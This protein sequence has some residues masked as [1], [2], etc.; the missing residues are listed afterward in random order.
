MPAGSF[1]N[2]SEPKVSA[3]QR[4]RKEKERRDR[5]R[6]TKCSIDTTLPHSYNIKKGK[7]IRRVDR[8]KRLMEKME[9][10]YHETE[11][12]ILEKRMKA[13][14][15]SQ[16][17]HRLE[18]KYRHFKTIN[19]PARLK[20][21]KWLNLDNHHYRR[22]LKKTPAT[23]QRK[24]WRE[25]RKK[26]NGAILCNP[27]TVRRQ[28]RQEEIDIDNVININN[29]VNAEPTFNLTE[30]NENYLEK[31]QLR[32]VNPYTYKRMKVLRD[33]DF[34][35]QVTAERMEK[36][37]HPTYTPKQWNMERKNMKHSAETNPYTQQRLKEAEVLSVDNYHF[38][39]RLKDQGPFYVKDDWLAERKEM[40]KKIIY[41]CK[42]NVEHKGWNVAP[43]IKRKGHESESPVRPSTSPNRTKDNTIMPVRPSSNKNS[44]REGGNRH[45]RMRTI[46]NSPILLKKESERLLKTLRQQQQDEED[47]IDAIVKEEIDGDAYE[48]DDFEEE[49][50]PKSINS[51]FSPP[52]VIITQGKSN[53]IRSPMTT[54]PTTINTFNDY[55]AYK[56]LSKVKK[57]HEVKG[58][59]LHMMHIG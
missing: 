17:D 39:R 21:Q 19:G 1:G 9:R 44:K 14:N 24:N 58:N 10:E 54:S 18:A 57:I 28:K 42:L 29:I 6:K 37:V 49:I 46:N 33:I 22:R 43:L 52:R 47:L 31:K 8:K 59:S 7:I 15:K 26:T 35:N 3:K 16:V 4:K 12:K 56:Q 55:E 20:Y 27:Y 11:N 38:Q 50:T 5:I 34:D 45:N 23:Y 25:W 40:E 2:G 32:L 48:D 41:M 30:N 51:E 53:G 13:A 36:H